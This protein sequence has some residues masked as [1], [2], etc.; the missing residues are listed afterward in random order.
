MAREES[1]FEIQQEDGT[2]KRATLVDFITPDDVMRVGMG[3]VAGEIKLG[4]EYKS[5]LSRKVRDFLVKTRIT[6]RG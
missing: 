5:A 3:A 4:L 2:R 1:Y 6:T